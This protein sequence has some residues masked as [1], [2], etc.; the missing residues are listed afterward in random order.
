VWVQYEWSACCRDILMTTHNNQTSIPSAEFKPKFSPSKRPQTSVLDRAATDN[1]RWNYHNII[2]HEV[3]LA[4]AYHIFKW[5]DSDDL[6]TDGSLC[7][8]AVG[9]NIFY[10][11]TVPGNDIWL[12]VGQG[13]LSIEA[14]RI[15]THTPLGRTPLNEWCPVAETSTLQHTTLTRDRHQFPRF[16]SNP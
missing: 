7:G 6:L 5:D 14:S 9:T 3:M 12:L 15:H 16:Y 4:L 13:L 11:A 2:Q 1:S 10:G 8:Y